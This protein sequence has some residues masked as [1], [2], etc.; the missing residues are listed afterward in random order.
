M[1]PDMSLLFKSAEPSAAVLRK[2]QEWNWR[3]FRPPRG[4]A[5]RG[6]E[7]GRELEDRGQNGLRPRGGTMRALPRAHTPPPRRH[8]FSS[9]EMHRNP[10]SKPHLGFESRGWAG[11]SNCCL[12]W[13]A[14][15]PAPAFRRSRC[16]R[17]E[18]TKTE[19]AA[20]GGHLGAMCVH[21]RSLTL[22]RKAWS[23]S[24]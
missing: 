5:A 24:A 7:G 9:P 3:A 23:D 15:V 19:A 20:R 4:R 22:G 11:P 8:C 17:E 18:D 13:R 2:L 6:G 10:F 12:P 16:P 14:I 21:S 1:F